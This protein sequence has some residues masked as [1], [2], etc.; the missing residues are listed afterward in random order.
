MLVTSLLVLME[1]HCVF[2]AAFDMTDTFGFPTE[3]QRRNEDFLAPFKMLAIPLNLRN[4][5]P[6]ILSSHKGQSLVCRKEA[7]LVYV[8]GTFP[9]LFILPRRFCFPMNRESGICWRNV[10][11][12]VHVL[13]KSSRL[14]SSFDH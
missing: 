7:P 9:L 3:S 2:L 11:A 12:S 6:G 4:H 5:E 8:M 1:G 10:S 14:C 13:K